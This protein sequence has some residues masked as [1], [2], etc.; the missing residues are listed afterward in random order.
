[1]TVT[2]LAFVLSTLT[3]FVVYWMNSQRQGRNLPPGP[4]KYPLIGNLFS[5][6]TTLGWKTFTK[7]GQEYSLYWI[8]SDFSLSIDLI[9]CTDSDI[10]H[11]SGLGT[12]IVILNS[13]KVATDLL[14]KRSSIY[15]SR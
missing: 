11:V 1:M 14:D 3:V 5:M 15:S 8:H 4:K 7:W 12:S 9:P 2:Q 6:P 13:Y 10:I